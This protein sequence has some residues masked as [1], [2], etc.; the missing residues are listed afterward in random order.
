MKKNIMD[1]LEQYQVGTDILLPTKSGE[2]I[3]TAFPPLYLVF[4]QGGQEWSHHGGRNRGYALA[5]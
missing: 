2:T 3:T 5:Q 4:A 1:P